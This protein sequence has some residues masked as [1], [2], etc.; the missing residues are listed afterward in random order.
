[1]TQRLALDNIGRRHYGLGEPGVVL[2]SQFFLVFEQ[3]GREGL[4]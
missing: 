3:L 2:V 1:L 4:D